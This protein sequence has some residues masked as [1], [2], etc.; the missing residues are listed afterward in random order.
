MADV[1]Q[2]SPL[3]PALERAHGLVAAGDLVRARVL[4]ERAVE[5][6]RENLGEDN[7][8][9]LA[10][11]REL[12]GVHRRAGDPVAARRVL[13]QAYAAGQWRLG[14]GDPL[15]LRISYDLGVVA[16]ELGNRH[17]ARRAF[18]RV[19]GQGPAAL[20]AH[21]WAVAQAQAY[22]N[23]DQNPAPVREK[24]PEPE[25]FPPSEV[26]ARRPPGPLP[27]Q[28]SPSP[29][30]KTVYAAPAD[31]T[32]VPQPRRDQAATHPLPTGLAPPAAEVPSGHDVM[33]APAS[34]FPVVRGPWA[35]PPQA[36]TRREPSPELLPAAGVGGAYPQETWRRAM[37][38]FLVVAATVASMIAI[39]ALVFVLVDRGGEL[40]PAGVPPLGGEPSA[41]TRLDGRGPGVEV[42]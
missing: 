9:V 15:L 26:P 35:E 7:P 38:L 41:A 2:P 37:A 33:N 10:T 13:E 42:T 29:A 8:D 39:A 32:D 1:W 4:L 23:Q 17:E 20:G 18:G 16:E 27:A 25:P 14:E 40:T 5:L 30:D 6:G 19:A 36:R 11:M 22:L 3:T 24:P 28:R 21:H 34:V 12:A 31:K